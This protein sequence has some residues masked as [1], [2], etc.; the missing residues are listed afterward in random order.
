MAMTRRRTTCGCQG[1]PLARALV[2]AILVLALTGCNLISRALLGPTASPAH[3]LALKI[4]RAHAADR[5]QEQPALQADVLF[6]F[7][8]GPPLQAKLLMET[9]TGRARME[10]PDGTTLGYDGIDAW[11]SP[12]VS[13][14][15]GARF[16]LLTWPHFLRLPYRLLAPGT[17]LADH[18]PLG[19]MGKVYDAAFVTFDPGLARAPGDWLILHAD[20]DTHRLKALAYVDSYGKTREQAE[21][22]PHLIVY[23]DFLTVSG[24]PLPAQWSIYHWTPERGREGK[25]I[26]YV[27]LANPRFVVPEPDSFRMPDD[28][29]LDPP[30]PTSE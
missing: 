4:E 1:L 27:R 22:D 16:H 10:L 6:D 15:P 2:V 18:P 20:P 7:H 14:F 23:A 25:A 28:A 26:G 8:D 11:V 5:W 21:A 29:R 24:V 12:A 9:A 17:N 3:E 13:T 19:L 30:P